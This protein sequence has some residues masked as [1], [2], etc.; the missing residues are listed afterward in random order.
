MGL[1][2]VLSMI[3]NLDIIHLIICILS[4]NF[5]SSWKEGVEG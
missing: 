1:Y 3:Y 5:I 2:I 4:T